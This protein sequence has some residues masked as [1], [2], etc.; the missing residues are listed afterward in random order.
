MAF[1]FSSRRRERRSGVSVVG[2]VRLAHLVDPPVGDG[3]VGV[4]VGVVGVMSSFDEPLI[5]VESIKTKVKPIRAPCEK[6]R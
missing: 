1:D 6:E 4:L 5:S 2:V 3:D